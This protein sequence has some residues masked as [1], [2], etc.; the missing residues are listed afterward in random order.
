[1]S[2][3]LKRYLPDIERYLS[4]SLPDDSGLEKDL[5]EAMRYSL[6]SGGKRIRPTLLLEF[7][8]LCGGD[9]K[10]ALPFACAVEMI[11]TYSLIHDDLP[12]MDDDD[13]RRGRPANHIAFG[14]DIA[15][16]AGDALQSLAFEAILCEKSVQGVG[17][18]KAVRAAAVLA[19][20]C[21]ALG[22]VGGQVID[23]Q[24]EGKAVDVTLLRT[25]DAKK[26]GAIIVA[27]AK[28]G[29]VLG[30]AADSQINAA[31]EYAKNIGLAFQIV[32]DIL[33]VT[34]SREELGKPIGSDKDNKKS[35]YVSILGLEESKRL[36]GRLTDAAISA[37][38]E[39]EGDTSSLQHLA[40]SLSVR[41]R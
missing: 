35:T 22:M 29:C 13:T 17:A 5:I 1:M 10:A 19:G 37:L 2:D 39:F 32:D 26:T 25:M 18:E 20:A 9:T 24:H 30:E 6:L 11:H 15:L 34:A 7:C 40:R 12:C 23:L 3:V 38:A 14:E 21:G 33:D 27:A 28:M 4:D 36:V 8:A 16:L 41:K 31:V